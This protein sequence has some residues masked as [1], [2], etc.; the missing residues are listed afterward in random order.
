M[1][2]GV[3]LLA[4]LSLGACK[5]DGKGGGEGKAVSS[6]VKLEPPAGWRALVPDADVKQEAGWSKWYGG[7]T[8]SVN[9][10]QAATYL[11]DRGVLVRVWCARADAPVPNGNVLTW[12]DVL[13]RTWSDLAALN[14]AYVENHV[15]KISSSPR[16]LSLGDGTNLRYTETR[17]SPPLIDERG[18]ETILSFG[19]AEAGGWHLYIGVGG[20]AP[21]Y[22][23]DEV[24]A[25]FSAASIT[26]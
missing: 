14:H 19:S 9:G 7:P 2:I 1:R 5:K 18:P 25:L 10:A 20:R 26:N 15:L 3:L 13:A 4:A 8:P 24:T 6:C 12:G 21:D 22:S 23:F 11:S 17:M 16:S